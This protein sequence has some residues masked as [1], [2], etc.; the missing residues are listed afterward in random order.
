MK[1][2]MPKLYDN[3]IAHCEE[4]NIPID[5][6]LACFG[7]TDEFVSHDIAFCTDLIDYA[8]DKCNN[9]QQF[10]IDY[11]DI[12]WEY[13]TPPCNRIAFYLEDIIDMGDWYAVVMGAALFESI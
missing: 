9:V 4:N 13:C 7:D 8:V 12:L 5:C 2:I 10:I 3:I 6:R 1:A 11:I